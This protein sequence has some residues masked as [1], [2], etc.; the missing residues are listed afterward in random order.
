MASTLIIDGSYGEGGGQIL[1]TSF[2]L[3]AILRRPIRIENIRAGRKNPGLQPQHLT[4]V[5]AV[6]KI[7]DGKLKGDS[8]RSSLLEFHPKEVRPGDYVFDV[9]DV[10]ASA[11]SVNLILQTIL[12]PLAFADKPSHVILR[13]GTHVPWSPP[14]NYI[15]DVYLPILSRMGLLAIYRMNKAG[16][17]PVGGGEVLLD[18]RPVDKLQP[19]TLMQRDDGHVTVYSAVSNLPMSIVERQ[20]NEAVGQLRQLGITPTE[21]EDEYMS[22]GKGTVAFILYSD[23]DLKAGFTGIGERGKPAET[24]AREAAE[25]FFEWWRSGEALDKHLADQ[26]ILPMSLAGGESEFSTSEITQHLLTNVHTVQ[27]FLPVHI[28]VDGKEG[29]P[30]TVRIVGEGIHR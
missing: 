15:D 11:G 14:S 20:M 6:A 30:G 18:V 12:L 1:R 16:Y 2:S 17:Y 13:G 25:D 19:L 3:A 22:P 26:L 21:V 9:S 4:A 8:I 27:Q 24:V 29:E 10:K 7:C 28:S 23:G 5:R